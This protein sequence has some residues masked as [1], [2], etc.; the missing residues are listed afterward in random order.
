MPEIAPIQGHRGA[1]AEQ[2]IC[3]LL[4]CR[5]FPS[6]EFSLTFGV[7]L[8]TVS[9]HGAL[10]RRPGVRAGSKTSSWLLRVYRYLEARRGG[11][12]P[13]LLA[14]GLHLGEVVFNTG[15]GSRQSGFLAI[16]S[17]MSSLGF[18][19]PLSPPVSHFT[20]ASRAIWK[21]RLVKTCLHGL[22][23]SPPS[24]AQVDSAAR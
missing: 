18:G 9:P 17:S 5:E 12:Q 23:R 16:R 8:Q 7:G 6:P 1:L 24:G 10:G 20:T 2:P 14:F 22:Q 15:G 3:P 11:T 19:L 4:P 21:Y 13:T